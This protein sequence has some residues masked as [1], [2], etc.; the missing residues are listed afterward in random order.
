M[1]AA[2]LSL[3]LVGALGVG[4]VYLGA[5]S[6]EED[7]IPVSAALIVEEALV[8]LDMA[9]GATLSDATLWVIIGGL[10]V[11]VAA[12]ALMLVILVRRRRSRRP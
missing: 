10:L 12:V 2:L 8:E 9:E 3:L 7:S 4:T 6:G 5:G 1:L 11:A